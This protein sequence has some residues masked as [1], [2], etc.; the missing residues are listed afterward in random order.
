[1]SP[2]LLLVG[3]LALL[4]AAPTGLFTR[5]PI[6]FLPL[7]WVFAV[8]AFLIGQEIAHVA[9]TN[10]ITLGEVEIGMGV[11]AYLLIM[12]ANW[13]FSLWYTQR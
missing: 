11:G 3:V 1:M 10:T 8:C 6:Y 5:K 13:L 12:V 9:H 2:Q 4:L 7:Y